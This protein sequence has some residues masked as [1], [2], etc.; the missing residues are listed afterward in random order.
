MASPAVMALY[1]RLGGRRLGGR[2]IAGMAVACTG[3]LLLVGNGSLAP[4][5]A[6]GPA[7]G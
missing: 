3:V 6:P 5:S 1:E 2:H 4:H 7:G